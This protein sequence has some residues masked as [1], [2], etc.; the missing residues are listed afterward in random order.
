MPKPNNIIKEIIPGIKVLDL[1]FVGA[2]GTKSL[3]NCSAVYFI[4]FIS[5]SSTV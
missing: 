3:N 2:N 1:G 5:L 4:L